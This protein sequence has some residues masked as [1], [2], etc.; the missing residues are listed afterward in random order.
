MRRQSDSTN[1]MEDQRMSEFVVKTQREVIF[2]TNRTGKTV[3]AVTIPSFR[4]QEKGLPVPFFPKLN[5]LN[6]A[7]M[8]AEVE[9]ALKWAGVDLKENAKQARALDEQLELVRLRRVEAGLIE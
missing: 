7:I 1:F 9:K 8:R 3:G 2:K 6:P 5:D 4:A